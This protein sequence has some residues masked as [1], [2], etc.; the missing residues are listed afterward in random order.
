MNK[1]YLEEKYRYWQVKSHER[2]MS[3]QL[4]SSNCPTPFFK[5]THPQIP[6]VFSPDQ[7]STE[8]EQIADSSIDTQE[9][10]GLSNRF[11]LSYSPLPD[12]SCFM[13]LFRPIIL[14]LLSTVDR[15]RNQFSVSKTI[16]AQL[17]RHDLP[18]LSRMASQ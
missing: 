14:I 11:E 17:I 3:D 5:R 12:P 13:R 2:N 9:S 1:G 8:I 4:A 7:M 6:I 18:R 10:L 16:A 15:L